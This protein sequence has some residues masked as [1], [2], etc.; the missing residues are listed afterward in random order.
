[1]DQLKKQKSANIALLGL[2]NSFEMAQLI[3]HPI[4]VTMNS[5]T[6]IY[7]ILVNNGHLVV[8]AS[9]IPSSISDHSF[10]FCI[11]KNRVVKK[12]PRKFEYRSYKH[13]NNEEIFE[14]Y[15]YS[16]LVYD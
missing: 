12:P 7:L 6:L 13:Y 5:K 9:A 2:I 10:I 15:F 11:I 4:R 16:T 8:L 1:M 3:K 14:R